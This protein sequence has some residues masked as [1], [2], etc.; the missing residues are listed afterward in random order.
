MDITDSVGST[1]LMVAAFRA[2]ETARPRPLFEDRFAS[3][4]AVEKITAFL[5]AWAASEPVVPTVI[6]VRTR[7]FNEALERALAGGAVQVV[8]LGAG[9]CC[10]SLLFARPGVTFFEIDRAEVL[11]FKAERLAAGGH[12]YP[13]VPLPIDYTA[14]RLLEALVS[15]GLDATRRTFVIWEGNTYYLPAPAMLTVLSVFAGLPDV[16]IALDYFHSDVAEGR[17]RSPGLRTS[18]ARLRSLGA[19]FLSGIDDT[20]ALGQRLGMRVEDDQRFLAYLERLLPEL[21]LGDDAHAEYGL[22]LLAKGGEPPR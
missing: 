10:R 18:I 1:A 12:R 6:R 2:S 11:A 13:A 14:P 4:F 16:R 21:D 3:L 20:G 5:D 15:G 9:C 8:V 17:S 19:P 7:W 22:C